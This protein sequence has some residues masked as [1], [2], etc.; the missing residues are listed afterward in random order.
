MTVL[1]LD[2]PVLVLPLL[3]FIETV[4]SWFL[5]LLFIFSLCYFCIRLSILVRLRFEFIYL[6]RFNFFLHQI[7]H[8]FDG[9]VLFLITPLFICNLIL[10][11]GFSFH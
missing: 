9:D 3:L 8:F 5:L 11:N 1:L 7:V 10:I 6:S 2:R 4:F